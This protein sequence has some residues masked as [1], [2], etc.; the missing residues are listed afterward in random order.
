MQIDN[1]VSDNVVVVRP[2]GRLT[3]ET[4][5]TFVHHFFRLIE[6]GHTHFVLDLAEV[7]S[8]DSIG[9]G[10]IVRAHTAARRYGGELKVANAAEGDRY[11]LS[12]TR[13]LTTV[14]TVRVD[15]QP[16]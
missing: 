2:H 6:A 13:L 10:A 7:P 9:L 16:T 15:E 4:S 5:R 14:D 3:V 11:L 1:R 8:I 12:I